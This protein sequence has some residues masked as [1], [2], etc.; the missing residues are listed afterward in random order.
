MTDPNHAHRT[1]SNVRRVRPVCHHPGCNAPATAEA[2]WL[3]TWPGTGDLFT[4]AWH[5]VCAECAIDD[6][7]HTPDHTGPSRVIGITLRPLGA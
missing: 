5:P 6:A 2:T 3:Q 7:T 1:R 4:G